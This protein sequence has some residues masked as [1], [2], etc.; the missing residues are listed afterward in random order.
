MLGCGGKKGMSPHGK[1][2]GWRHHPYL[3]RFFS[4]VVDRSC[5]LFP[6]M[7]HHEEKKELPFVHIQDF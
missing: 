2:Q 3:P 1:L 6:K 4:Q 7:S 5:E